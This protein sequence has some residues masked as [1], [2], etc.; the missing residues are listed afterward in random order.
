M[1]ARATANT[2]SLISALRLRLIPAA[3]P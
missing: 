3:R 2:A 1:N